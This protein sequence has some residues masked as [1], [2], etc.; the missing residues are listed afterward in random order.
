MLKI[1]C[2]YF[3]DLKYKKTWYQLQT[4]KIILG[5]KYWLD[6]IRICVFLVDLIAT[7]SSQQV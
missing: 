3:Q 2:R 1:A 6:L 5:V 7:G 4:K